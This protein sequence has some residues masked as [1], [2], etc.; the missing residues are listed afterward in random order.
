[1]YTNLLRTRQDCYNWIRES[2]PS[3]LYFSFREEADY[4]CGNCQ[5]NYKGGTVGL[6]GL[7]NSNINVWKIY[8]TEKMNHK[9]D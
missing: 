6:G 2:Y 4:F 1:M 5:A 8:T 3:S 7:D 9:L